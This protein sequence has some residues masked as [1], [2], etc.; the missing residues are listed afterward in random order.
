MRPRASP[1]P[2]T[3]RTASLLA[4][5]AALTGCGRLTELTPDP[6]VTPVQWCEQRPC[7]DWGSTVINEP[8]SSALVFLL[9]LAWIGVGAYFLLTRRRQRSRGWFGVALVL[10]GV[11]AALAGIS[12]QLFSYALKCAGRDN[13]LLTNGFEV[14]YSICQA[15]SVSAMIAAVAYAAA[16]GRGRRD[17]LWYAAANV[18]TYLVVA[19]L[20]TL[21]P[22]AALLSFEVLTLFAVP[23]III[24]IVLARRGAR[25]DADGG[26]LAKYRDLF[27]AAVLL[28]L[29]QV[30]YFAY[31]AAGITALLWD[32]GGGIYF[33]ENDVLHVG[34]LAWLCF[35]AVTLGRSLADREST[36]EQ[37]RPDEGPAGA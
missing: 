9:A 27:W 18:A 8:F 32:G 17:L 22:S 11:G 35:V 14:W 2:A 29:V 21:L 1:R 10:G 12:Y 6:P 19:S 23:G 36:Q 20:G 13:C 37:P 7:V 5:V 4:A 3:A 24:A 15:A 30:A 16:A 33:S 28:A 25:L 26:S 34:M 31:Y